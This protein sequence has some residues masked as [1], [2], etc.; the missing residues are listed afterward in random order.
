MNRPE[1][2]GIEV[3]LFCKQPESTLDFGNRRKRLFFT[4]FN[5]RSSRCELL[6]RAVGHF[7]T[8]ASVEYGSPAAAISAPPAQRKVRR[9]D[10]RTRR[11]GQPRV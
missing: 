8:P 1:P 7:A 6:C 2:T 4:C 9:P 11:T 5:Y 3:V 10:G